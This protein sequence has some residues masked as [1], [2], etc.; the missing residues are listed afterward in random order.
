MLQLIKTVTFSSAGVKL[1]SDAYFSCS[2][3]LLMFSILCYPLLKKTQ[4]L[5]ITYH[6]IR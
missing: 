1:E 5:R 6:V 4:V 3:G 2:G